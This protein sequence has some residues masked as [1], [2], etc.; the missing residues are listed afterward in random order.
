MGNELDRAPS[1]RALALV[2]S[3]SARPLLEHAAAQA[4]AEITFPADVQNAKLALA[5]PGP[6]VVLVEAGVSGA[7][8]FCL[9]TRRVRS[10]TDTSV[11]VGVSRVNDVAFARAF[12]WQADDVVR[13]GSERALATRL[14]ARPVSAPGSEEAGGSRRSA[15][16]ADPD[17][18]RAA[19]TAE[20]V[21]QAGYAAVVVSE[22]ERALASALAPAPALVIWYAEL[23]D[24][25]GALRLARESGLATRWLVVTPQTALS[26]ARARLA[27]D[28]YARAVSD[29]APADQVLYF[30]NELEHAP[31]ESRADERLLFGT[32]VVFR[33][34]GDEEDE[35]AFTHDVSRRGLRVRTLALP[36]A[37][38][39]WLELK[40]P[41]G[42]RRVRL[43]GEVVWRRQAGALRGATAPP[44]FGVQL[45]GGLLEDLALWEAGVAAFRAE[46]HASERMRPD[47]IVPHSAEAPAASRVVEAHAS[48]PTPTV[49]AVPPV[50]QKRWAPALSDPPPEIPMTGGGRWAWVGMFVLG[51]LTAAVAWWALAPKETP[52]TSAQ[53][54]GLE[55]PANSAAERR[56]A[57]PSAAPKA[58]PLPSPSSAVRAAAL[59]APNLPGS[60][61]A[62][63]ANSAP[64]IAD[65]AL[66]Q[67]DPRQGFLWVKTALAGEV[68]VNGKSMGQPAA[69][70][71]VPCGLRYV[72]VGVLPGPR[73]I[74]RGH[75]V[76]VA[77]RGLT[78]VTIER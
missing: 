7:E 25:F 72:R 23:G 68:F 48:Q 46:L 15:V 60:A 57:S 35:Y 40:P 47:A 49:E 29:L 76:R 54:R 74:S 50:A 9:H 69:A 13:L 10:P 8:E 41:N 27:R 63:V 55:T 61:G 71:V 44:G 11:V 51:S 45:L 21:A 24:A 18:P 56:T 22:F 58:P 36:E 64:V 34:E 19:R 62:P 31:Q 53:D 32:L 42:R 20:L 65:D 77:C 5:S 73:W 39:V 78:E 75:T 30:A 6:L 26:E 1:A 4:G 43:A 38:R 12:S 17:A 33:G 3:A 2:A 14:R 59:A 16:I 70:L 37:S 66:A 67:L 52:D 28:R